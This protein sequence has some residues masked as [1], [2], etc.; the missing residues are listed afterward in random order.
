MTT[1]NITVFIAAALLA[2]SSAF[3][4]RTVQTSSFP[5]SAKSTHLSMTFI[6]DILSVKTK[7]FDKFAGPIGFYALMLAPVY[8]IGLPFFG[9]MTDFSTLQNRG[10]PGVIANE[11]IVAPRDFTPARASTAPVFDISAADLEKAFDTVVLRQPRISQI[12]TDE[13]TNRR[14]YVQRALLFRW[15]DVI[16]FQAIPLGESK[17]TLAV[18]SY[19]IY[20]AGDLGVNA[21]RVNTWLTELETDIDKKK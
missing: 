14:E 10:P 19:S 16:T 17:S 4:V 18:H 1:I 20:G 7:V 15:P 11:Y 9:S 6:E 5:R 21:N 12:A 13:S 2:G 3:C 8:G